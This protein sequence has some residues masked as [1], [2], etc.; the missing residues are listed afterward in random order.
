MYNLS[1]TSKIFLLLTSLSGS[2]WMGG[3]FARL[4]VF[5]QLFQPKELILR[6][7]FNE[8]NLHAVLIELNSLIIL[9]LVLY[10]LFIITYFI[11]I[12]TSK[13]SL[14]ENG[15]LFIVTVIIPDEAQDFPMSIGQLDSIDNGKRLCDL[16][17]PLS[18][19]D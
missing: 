4:I 8:Q 17:I 6:P 11:F 10:L 13:I 2:L 9:T 1:K 7:V 16:L 15:W 19:I 12:T 14:R 18:H 3:Y 5:Y